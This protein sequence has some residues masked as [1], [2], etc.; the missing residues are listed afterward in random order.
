MKTDGCGVG[1][2]IDRNFFIG[3][4]MAICFAMPGVVRPLTGQETSTGRAVVTVNSKAQEDVTTVPRQTMSVFENRKPQELTGWVALR[5]ERSGLQLV[6]LLDD[7]SRGNLG[8]Q[9]NDIKSFLNGLP[10]TTQV[11]IGYMRNGTPNLVQNFT[12]D[13]AQAAKALR[14][15]AGIGGSNGSPYFCLSDLV[16]HWPGGDSNVRREVIMVTDG[17]D[18]YS[19][20]RFDP[21]NPYV[22]AATSDA[23]KAGVIVYSIYYRGA[24]RLDRSLLVTDGGQ[25]YLTQVSGDTGGKV[26]LEGFGNPVSFAPFLSDIQR[27]LQ[28]QYELTFASTAKPGL[29]NIRVKT[30]QPNTTL[31]WPARIPIGGVT[32]AP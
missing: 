16:K 5:G 2:K 8:L 32:A 25:N 18:R 26:Y 28:N 31:Q 10:P 6:V 27:K 4:V 29:Q 20:A 30:S 15:P 13:H 11:A 14:L 3:L 17:V 21:E 23:Q 24:G 12:S 7:S 9:L 1:K 19:G 22:R